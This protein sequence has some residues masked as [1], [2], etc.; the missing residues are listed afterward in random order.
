MSLEQH[1]P[2]MQG[3]MSDLPPGETVVILASPDGRVIEVRDGDIV[4]RTAV[5][6]EA[7]EIHEEISRRHARFDLSEGMWFIMDLG[8][9]NG[10]FL[11][12][13]RLPSKERVPVRNGQQLQISPVFRCVVRIEGAGNEEAALRYAD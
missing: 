6:K 12:G 11:E 1:K 5:G 10:T 8:S 2:R 4:G 13:Q 7:L 9:S 3:G